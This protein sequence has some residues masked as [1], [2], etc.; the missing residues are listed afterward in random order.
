MSST[1]YQ[2]D[3]RDLSI[4]AKKIRREKLVPGNLHIS[5]KEKPVPVQID[6]VSLS[7]LLGEN[8]YSSVIPVTLE[9]SSYNVVIKEVQRAHLGNSYVH[10]DIQTVKKGEVMT[11]SV[12]L[13][14]VGE[15]AL[16]GKDIA[17]QLSV[18]ELQLKGAIEKL[19]DYI[20]VNVAKMKSG[21]R[22]SVENLIFP[23][24][25]E[26]LD[27]ATHTVCVA[28]VHTT[29][30]IEEAASEEAPTVPLVAEDAE[31]E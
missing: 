16:K 17:I 19:P 18:D 30:E 20:E 29:S 2:L 9:K 11:V 22:I 13:K 10:F 6:E 3:H 8:S 28:S 26:A 25:I 21:D 31:K 14:I 24:G 27:E 23:E 15:E 1:I 4:R 5:N 7:K 12:P